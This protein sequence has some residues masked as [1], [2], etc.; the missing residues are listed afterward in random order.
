MKQSTTHYVS[1]RVLKLNVGFLLSA[2][3]GHSHDTEFHAPA[4]RVSDDVAVEYIRG[5]L[6]LFRTKE[7]LL[8]RGWLQV[9]LTDECYRCLDD[10]PREITFEVE[11]LYSY[12]T[13]DVTEYSISDDGVLDRLYEGCASFQVIP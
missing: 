9:G 13:P 6:R 11:E 4:V 12:P 8:V 5:P 3:P 7:G 2:G 10:V 1:N